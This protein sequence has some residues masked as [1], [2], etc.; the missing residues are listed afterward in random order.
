MTHVAV[1]ESEPERTIA[2]FEFRGGPFPAKLKSAG[3][4]QA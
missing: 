2:P 1:H 3:R 4:R